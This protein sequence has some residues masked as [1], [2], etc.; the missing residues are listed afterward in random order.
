MGSV[1]LVA[2][3]FMAVKFDVF[4]N[5]FCT[6]LCKMVAIAVV[7][8]LQ[9]L[10]LK[11]C[12]LKHGSTTGK[13]KRVLGTTAITWAEAYKQSIQ[14]TTKYTSKHD[15]HKCW[16]LQILPLQTPSRLAILLTRNGFGT[17]TFSLEIMDRCV[18]AVQLW[19][20]QMEQLVLETT[21]KM[22]QYLKGCRT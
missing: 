2:F 7:H 10:L 19:R 8:L 5:S 15:F 11:G 12:I 21:I 4:L 17:K 3:Q 22:I 18:K 9:Q 1:G 13:A 16:N 6:V 14:Q 20:Q